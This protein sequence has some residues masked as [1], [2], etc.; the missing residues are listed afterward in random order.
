MKLLFGLFLI[1][2]GL[3]HGAYLTADYVK[4][5]AYPFSVDKS[6]LITKYGINAVLIKPMVFGLVLLSLVGFI[7]AGFSYLG[8]VVPRDWFSQIVIFSSFA[9]LI[10]MFVTWNNYF[11]VGALIDVAIIIAVLSSKI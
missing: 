3:I 2:H 7:L 4:D 9:S 10:L 5:S 6:W 11:I 1:I 8:W